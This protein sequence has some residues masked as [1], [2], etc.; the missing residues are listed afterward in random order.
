M[1]KNIRTIILLVLIIVA[2]PL[3]LEFLVFDNNIPSFV[4]NDGWAG[5][6]GAYIGAIIG[7]VTTYVTVNLEIKNNEK[8]RKEEVQREFRPYLYFRAE[9]IDE[10]KRKVDVVL[11]NFGKYAACDIKAYIVSGGKRH[12]AWNQHFCIGGNSDFQLFVALLTNSDDYYIYE[13][14]DILGRKYEQIVRICIKDDDIYSM[15]F[16]SEEPVLIE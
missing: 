1:K 10:K 14:K 3:L 7:A 6:F 12:L 9:E 8:I 11:N 15:D 4:S 16:S 5:F 2:V 13:F